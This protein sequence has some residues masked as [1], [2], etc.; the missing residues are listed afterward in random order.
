[1]RELQV[2]LDKFVLRWYQ[3]PV[4]EAIEE[5]G[6]KRVLYV[7][8]RRSGK[9][10]LGF[11]LA[12][13]Q[14]LKRVCL[15]FYVL[16]TYAQGRKAIFDAITIDGMKFL[17][18]LPHELVE[19]INQQEMK[20]VFKNNSILQVIGGDSYDNSLVGTNPYAVILSEYSL[21]PPEIFSYI[22]PILAANGGWCL[23][24]GTPRGK[25]HM[26]QLFQLANILPDWKVV[27]QKT[28][29]IHHISEEV[30]IQERAEM[31]EGLFLQEY[32]CSFERGISG[33][34]YGEHL[35][36]LKLKGQICPVAWEPGLLVHT[37]WD[38]GV[39]DPC[40]ILW[41][42]VI[43]DGT[44]IR[45]IDCYSNRNLGVDHYINIVNNKPYNYGKHFAP[46][47]IK[48]REFG[49]G[50]IT[51]YEQARQLG[52]TFTPLPQ[53]DLMEGIEFCW[54]HFNKLWID[55]EKCRSLLDALENY[56]KEWDEQRQMYNNKPV[57]TKWNHYADAFRYL[58]QSIHRTKK[59]RDAHEFD[60]AKAEALYGNNRS[61]L[62]R[63]FRDDI[64]YDRYR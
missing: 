50:A 47:D 19:R 29:E 16:P 56:R 36:K 12:I 49:A 38:L 14:C 3:L 59:G 54:M 39:N 2:N 1:M 25:N 26:W 52:F 13:R 37:A 40:A 7:A 21:M 64:S 41:F 17:D 18:F 23:F 24:V 42:Q 32:E 45:I 31:E 61:D 43:G 6:F 22:R 44:V 20:I 5:Q 33:S 30:I 4:F 63:F 28:S 15:V 11:N 58:I 9:D 34:F 62:P 46:F 27:L 8:P 35:D 53:T 51:R 48:V 60:R 55:A 57:K 10:V